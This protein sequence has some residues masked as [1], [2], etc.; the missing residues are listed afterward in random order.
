MQNNL[1]FPTQVSTELEADSTFTVVIAYED[2]ETGKQAKKTCDYLAERMEDE[3]QVQQQMWKFDVLGVTKLREMAADDAAAADIIIVSAHGTNELPPE[4]KAWIELW[5]PQPKKSIALVA[6]LDTV[7]DGNNNPVRN[8]LA[9]VARRAA[10]EFFSQPGTW[11]ASLQI[12]PTVTRTGAA[13]GDLGA[14]ER[15]ISTLANLAEPDVAAT[16]WGINE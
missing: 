7:I 14:D 8:Y 9:D 13:A 6:L 1:H 16:H 5:V 10:L 15:T 2:F 11:P 12:Q 3:C 4:V